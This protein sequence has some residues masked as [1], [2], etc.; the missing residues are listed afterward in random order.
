[1]LTETE[2]DKIAQA[3][4]KPALLS[5]DASDLAWSVLLAGRYVNKA[6]IIKGDEY[7]F[8][9]HPSANHALKHLDNYAALWLDNG[10]MLVITPTVT[11]CCSD[12]RFSEF[13][14][15]Q[16]SAVGDSNNRIVDA[17]MTGSDTYGFEEY[18]QYEYTL[19]VRLETGHVGVSL[20]SAMN[21]YELEHDA[22]AFEARLIEGENH[23]N[24]DL[25]RAEALLEL[26]K[27]HRLFESAIGSD[28]YATVTDKAN[29]PIWGGMLR[30]ALRESGIT[31]LL[32]ADLNKWLPKPY[33]AVASIAQGPDKDIYTVRIE[34][35]GPSDDDSQ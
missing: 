17:Y 7:T 11:G 27:E 25:A 23:S 9:A 28:G 33:R 2:Q 10:D 35:D 16:A 8:K 12:S 31:D 30:K 13:Y 6:A 19:Y 14:M 20:V 15:A 32:E 4:Q 1:M 18:T 21:A 34:K 29:D 22:H 3:M 5:S 26:A 24:P